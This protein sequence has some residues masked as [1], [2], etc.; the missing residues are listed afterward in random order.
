MSEGLNVVL[1]DF[2]ALIDREITVIKYCMHKYPD[3][4]DMDRLH[5]LSIPNLEYQRMYGKEDLLCSLM[6]IDQYKSNPFDLI[7]SLFESD[8]STLFNQYTF[9]TLMV[10]LVSAY[11]KTGNGVVRAIIR[12]DDDIQRDYSRSIIKDANTIISKREDIDTSM[13]GRFITSHYKEMMEY[14]IEDFKSLI[15]L[16]YAE[17]MVGKMVKPE[18]II[19]FGD[20]NSIGTASPFNEDDFTKG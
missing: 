6:K 8:A 14:N 7:N 9:N 16:K 1:I 2:W 18:L 20:T 3:F 19:K 13:Y 4:I 15:V 17:N 12:C 5:K 10:N 11:N